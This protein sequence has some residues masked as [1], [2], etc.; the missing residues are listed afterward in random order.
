MKATTTAL[1]FLA[2]AVT[3]T[4][5]APQA[6]HQHAR[7][8]NAKEYDVLTTPDADIAALLASSS[9]AADDDVISA[10]F[11]NPRFRGFSGA[12]T[13]EEVATLRAAEGVVV[14]VREAVEEKMVVP[15]MR[16][17]RRM[18]M[19]GKKKREEVD[20]EKRQESGGGVESRDDATWGLQRISQEGKVEVV[21]GS[22][23]GRG[24]T[25]T[26]KDTSTLGAGVDI[27]VMDSGIY[28]EHEEFGGRAIE[29]YNFY[30]DQPGDKFG[31]GSHCAGSAAGST[32]GV[33]TNA[34]L[35]SVKV[36]ADDGL[37]STSG[38]LGGIDWILSR[39]ANRS[40]E[41][42][43]VASVVSISLSWSRVFETIDTAT[44]ELTAAGLHVA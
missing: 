37:G 15:E 43:F 35:I 32:V 42:D 13:D 12:F 44:K 31:H 4:A 29:G 5:A 34:S 3:T 27:Y 20:V 25:Y 14:S 28:T 18:G 2:A 8:Q 38:Y 23:T 40:T 7:R 6:H 19:G 17:R 10:T 9:I 39:H 41:A 36:I 30:P 22:T 11:D 16:R 26:W 1:L 24:Y 33:A 21:G